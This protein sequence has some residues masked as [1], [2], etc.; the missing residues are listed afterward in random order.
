[1]LIYFTVI[2]YSQTYDL[3]TKS[4]DMIVQKS[5]HRNLSKHK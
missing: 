5:N 3:S 2:T 4:D 1:M